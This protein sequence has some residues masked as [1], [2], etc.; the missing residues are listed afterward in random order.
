MY[1]AYIR[2]YK[3]RDLIGDRQRDL[4]TILP[5]RF[6]SWSVCQFKLNIFTCKMVDTNDEAKSKENY[7]KFTNRSI[8]F[9]LSLYP[10]CMYILHIEPAGEL[11]LPSSGVSLPR[12]QSNSIRLRV[13]FSFVLCEL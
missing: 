9:S 10:G 12:V 11:L 6:R 1:R 7:V 8:N 5:T 4:L 2:T 13:A 3:Y